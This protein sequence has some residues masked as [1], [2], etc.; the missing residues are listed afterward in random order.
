MGHHV[1]SFAA[2][3][4]HAHRLQFPQA[5]GLIVAVQYLPTLASFNFIKRTAFIRLRVGATCSCSRRR[6]TAAQ[7]VG[8]SLGDGGLETDGSVRI[9]GGEALG[10]AHDGAGQ[11]GTAR[12][13]AEHLGAEHVDG[14]AARDGAPRGRARRRSSSSGRSTSG[15]STSRQV[16]SGAGRSRA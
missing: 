12:V 1:G 7:G 10:A 13:G 2:P 4:S 8:A 14:R 5:D 16:A 15:Q 11:L 9:G 3:F 6:P